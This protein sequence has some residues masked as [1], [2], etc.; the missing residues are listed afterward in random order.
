MSK[1]SGILTFVILTA[2][3]F[4]AAA[5]DVVPD[6]LETLRKENS[7][8]RSKVLEQ[9]REL[10][11]MRAW[12]ADVISG[13]AELGKDAD[14]IRKLRLRT[15][16]DK[17]TLLALKSDSVS[18]SFRTFLKQYKVDEVTRINCILLLDELDAAAQ[19]FS[20]SVRGGDASTLDMRVISVNP[21]LN[22]AVVS[23]G[24]SSGIFVGMILYPANLRNSK[25][26]FRV[27]SVRQGV[28]AVDL[29]E[30]D[31]SDVVSGMSLTPFRRKL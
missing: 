18:K 15:V 9:D 1:I 2:A 5:G 13:E 28:C 23:G 22:I 16:I 27:V 10:A 8:L 11:R 6:A 20:G 14:A 21:K 29:K 25:L 30:G 3:V 31:W 17:G 12:L 19:G 7:E 4:T 26:T 24:M